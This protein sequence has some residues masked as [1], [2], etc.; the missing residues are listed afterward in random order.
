MVA[1]PAA[2][3]RARSGEPGAFFL[4]T[5][6][7]ALVVAA[8]V[9]ALPRPTADPAARG[10]GGRRPAASRPATSPPASTSQ[11]LPDDELADL[12]RSI[13][14]MADELETRAG[15]ERAFLLSVSHDLR[16]PLTSIRGYAEAIADGTV[17]APPRPRPRRAT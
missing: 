17:D 6:A 7:L 15:H 12:A 3:R 14:A 9:V 10:D 8:I 1:H 16:T 4:V 5:G 2:S 13:N 11:A